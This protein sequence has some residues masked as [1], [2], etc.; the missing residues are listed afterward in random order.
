MLFRS[1]RR[2]IYL[3]FKRERP[4]G[5]LE[6]LSVFD[7]PH[8]NDIVGERGNSTV[9]TQALFLTN[10]PFMKD[11][12]RRMAEHWLR[13]EPSDDRQRLQRLLMTALGRSIEEPEIEFAMQFIHACRED[14]IQSGVA[15]PAQAN[16]AA[17]TEYCHAIL[18]SNE[19]LFYE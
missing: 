13:I 4:T 16:L 10:S 5:E 6:I 3:P 19:F 1:N 17:W 8:P 18:G 7:F 2:T 9:P 12:S 11:H 14:Y 15:D